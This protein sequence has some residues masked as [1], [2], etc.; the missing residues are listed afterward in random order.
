MID[1][2]CVGHVVKPIVKIFN[3]SNNDLPSYAHPTVSGMDIKAFLDE[4]CILKPFERKLIPTGIYVELPRGFEVQVR[5]RSGLALKK[6]L[7]VLNSPG[8]VDEGYR[9]EI[10]VILINLSG[11]DQVISPGEK[12]AQL[13]LA[14]V[15][16]ACVLEIE[17]ISKDTDRGDTGYGD[18]GRF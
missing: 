6:G 12:I 2:P 9:G 17:D 10:G 14:R 4:D 16:Q 1:K 3:K 11:E 8:T 15:E 7:T 18:S 5:P 13:V